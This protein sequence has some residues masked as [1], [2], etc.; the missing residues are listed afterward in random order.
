VDSID[1]IDAFRRRWPILVIT[2]LLGAV[3]AFF[4]TSA[5]PIPVASVYTATNTLTISSAS[6]VGNLGQTVSSITTSQIPLYVAQGFVPTAVKKDLGYSAAV[7]AVIGG[8]NDRLDLTAT[9]ATAEGAQA[10]ADAY[11]DKLVAFLTST[12][13]RQRATLRDAYDVRLATLTARIADFSRQLAANPDDD[14]LKA[15][16]DAA[17]R[18]YSSTFEQQQ[19]LDLNV[20][21]T[22][23]LSSL[24]PSQAVKVTTGGFRTP[25]SR[26]T[27]VPIAAFVGL[28]L[29]LALAFLLE[30]FD[31]RIRDRRKAEQA[32]GAMTIAELPTLP[33][34][35]RRA[36]LIVGPD[37]QDHFAEA[38]RTLRTSV[39]FLASAGD[40]NAGPLSPLGVVLVT[41][42]SPSE[43]KTTT[44]AN[45]AA[46]FAETGRSVIVVNADFRR[47]RISEFFTAI[48]PRPAVAFGS[49]DNVR[50]ETLLVD[51]DV[52]GVRILDLS[53]LGAPAGALARAT[54]RLVESLRERVDVIIIDSPPLLVSAE[55]LEFIPIA[56]VAMLSARIGRSRVDGAKR[57][58]E[59][60]HFGG[61][62]KVAVVL[63]E[64]KSQSGH[65][66]RYYR[67]YGTEV[68]PRQ[69]VRR[70]KAVAIPGEP[71]TIVASNGALTARR[72]ATAA[73]PDHD[74]S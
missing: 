10:I 73:E 28:L 42:A 6:G 47:P 24:G 58:G 48:R 71:E 35:R 53:T 5:A 50:P 39:T 15:K 33:R 36:Q 3:F 4:G 52:P 13:L 9:A 56:N 2:A 60:V 7:S 45:L 1:Y 27:R 16:H 72:I 67:Y 14:I 19:N 23:N 25:Q 74:G 26:Q 61:V 46:A 57:A 44:A 22:I 18:A 38:Y 12:Q 21:T 20:D 41:S 11:A 31:G 63:N 59:L 70:A 54:R 66:G 30:R 43:G 55:A 29:G 69:R 62:E 40:P 49:I 32:F 65:H 37:R 17:V 51:S 68:E 34:G 8:N 64:A